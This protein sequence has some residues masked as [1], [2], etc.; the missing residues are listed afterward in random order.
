[1]EEVPNECINKLDYVFL[2]T[3]CV[4]LIQIYLVCLYFRVQTFFLRFEVFL[5]I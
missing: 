3:L 1:M 2:S 4:Q 5:L